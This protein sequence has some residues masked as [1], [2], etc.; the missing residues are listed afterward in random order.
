MCV[1]AKLL[2]GTDKLNATLH[3]QVTHFQLVHCLEKARNLPRHPP[4]LPIPQAIDEH[5]LDEDEDTE[6]IPAT[7]DSTTGTGLLRWGSNGGGTG[8]AGHHRHSSSGGGTSKLKRV[9]RSSDTGG[10]S[11]SKADKQLHLTVKIQ[12]GDQEPQTLKPVPLNPDGSAEV[13]QAAVF[14]VLRPL[15]EAVITYQLCLGRGPRGAPVLVLVVQYSLLHQLRR[16]PPHSF[17]WED[18]RA[19]ARATVP[20][21]QVSSRFEYGAGILSYLAAPAVIT[22]QKKEGNMTVVQALLS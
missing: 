7:E 5:L 10:G 14:G 16:S 21:L 19:V 8:G 12:L 11:S 1:A 15:E 17:V 20:G 18:W 2:S 22:H 6:S 3:H 4:L 13:K 9:G